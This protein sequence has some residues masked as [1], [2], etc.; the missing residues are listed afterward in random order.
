MPQ[1]KSGYKNNADP[2]YCYL[3][4]ARINAHL[5]R[6]GHEKDINPLTGLPGTSCIEANIIKRISDPS[7]KLGMLRVDLDNLKAFN[8]VYGLLHGDKVINLV[9]E[10]LRE[11]IKTYGNKDDFIGHIGGDNFVVIT[12]Q[13]NVDMI[14]KQI[15]NEFD[16]R[17]PACY[18]KDDVQRGYIMRDK[19]RHSLMSMSIGCATN[20]NRDIRNYQDFE[21]IAS[22]EMVCVKK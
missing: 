19:E 3:L 12:S 10:V 16:R 2:D 22:E 6:I 4:V 9:A 11:V 15:T 13:D 20:R 7:K 21:R 1:I 18:H 5:R 17:I 14:S 8:D